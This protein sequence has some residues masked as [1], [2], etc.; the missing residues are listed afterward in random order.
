[1]DDG[2]SA[3]EDRRSELT[4]V[5]DERRSGFYRKLRGRVKAWAASRTGRENRWL[6]YILAAPDLF[7]LLCALAL[8]P[9]IPAKH[10]ARL[11][12]VIAYFISPLDIMPEAL[13][14]PFGYLDDIALAA[15]FLNQL[16]NRVDP[17]VVRKH[18]AGEGDVLERVEHII[19]VADEMVGSGLWKKVKSVLA[20]DAGGFP[21]RPPGPRNE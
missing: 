15:Y 17:A 3:A 11:G 1:M 10:K 7:H 4:V 13:L 18:W 6:E 2:G 5:E 8:E 20:D 16:V 12:V 9:A 21:R 19:E 14:G